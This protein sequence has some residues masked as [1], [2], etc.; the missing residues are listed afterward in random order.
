MPRRRAFAVVDLH[1]LAGPKEQA[2]KLHGAPS[3]LFL[4]VEGPGMAVLKSYV[5][6]YLFDRGKMENV[7][8]SIRSNFRLFV[9]TTKFQDREKKLEITEHLM[10]AV[11]EFKQPES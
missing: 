1:L 9:A 8:G 7:A 3:N 10:E 5:T 11:F 6:A 2:G 4:E